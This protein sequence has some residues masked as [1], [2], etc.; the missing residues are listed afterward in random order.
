S[1]RRRG[2]SRERHPRA[3][4]RHGECPPPGRREL[5]VRRRGRGCVGTERA[6]CDEA[7]VVQLTRA[8]PFDHV[9]RLLAVHAAVLELDHRVEALPAEAL[10]LVAPTAAD[11]PR[12]NHVLDARGVELALDTPARMPR[13]LD[14]EVR[15]AMQLDGDDRTLRRR[16]EPRPHVLEQLRRLGPERDLTAE[17]EY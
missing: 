9:A 13:D 11:G 1:G 3:P 6:R 5:A 8:D 4:A 14:P 15:A 10:E 16:R 17:V 12:D 7:G 2:A